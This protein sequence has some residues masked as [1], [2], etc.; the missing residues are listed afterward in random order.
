MK[1][2]FAFFAGGCA[3]VVVAWTVGLGAS[4]CLAWEKPGEFSYFRLDRGLAAD[5]SRPLPDNLESDESLAWKTPL[6]PGHSTPCVHGNWIFVTTHEGQELATLGIDRATGEIRWKQVTPV[7]QLEAY[8]VTNSPAVATPA[9]DGERVY[10]FFGSYGIVCFGLDGTPVWSLPMPLAQD[11]FGSASSP[12]LE[13][14]KLILHGDH[15]LNSFLM[16]VDAKTGELVWKTMREGF[17]RSY[18]TPIIWEAGGQRQLIVAGALELVAYDPAD[19]EKLWWV[20]GLARIVNTTPAQDGQRLYVATW[21]PGGDTDAR[22]AMDA[23]PAAVKKWDANGDGK[24]TREELSDKEVLDRFFRIDLNQDLG[25]EQ[26]EW[27]K[28]A[29][30]FEL[31]RNTLLAIR[32]GGKGDVTATHVDWMYERGLPYVASPLLY[33]DVLYLAKDGGIFSSLAPQSGTLHKQGRLRGAGPYYA[34][35]VAGDGKVYVISEPGLLSILEA[36]PEWRTISSRDFAERTVATP[37]IADGKIYIRTE[38]ALY[39]FGY[40]R[41]AAI[42]K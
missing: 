34:S 18:S 24:L 36:G 35:P 40:N 12:I 17:T 7:K 14:G 20:N 27:E 22:V 16:A 5:D 39:C 9:C 28:Y 32:P 8:H 31:A 4:L 11:E 15:D 10:V 25:L 33:R 29:K 2:R 42:E 23:W 13:G 30:V 37:V 38:K 41:P 3:S 19:G 6:P 26:S 21:S 1:T